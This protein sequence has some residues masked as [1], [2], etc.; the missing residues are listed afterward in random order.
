MTNFHYLL[1]LY[2]FKLNGPVYLHLMHRLYCTAN[3]PY[4]NFFF[5][6]HTMHKPVQLFLIIPG[7]E[8][9]KGCAF[10][11]Y[12]RNSSCKKKKIR[13][14]WI[15]KYSPVNLKSLIYHVSKSSQISRDSP[16][17]SWPSFVGVNAGSSGCWWW[18]RGGQ[19]RPPSSPSSST[20]SSSASTGT[21]AIRHLLAPAHVPWQHSHRQDA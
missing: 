5:C 20:T 1:Y 3:I 18:G 12:L 9:N 6:M 10:L 4:K 14:T 19:A 8:V 21:A 16:F 13:N 15:N 17:K 11:P 2:V 7:I